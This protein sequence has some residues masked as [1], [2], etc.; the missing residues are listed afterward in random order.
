MNNCRETH[1]RLLHVSKDRIRAERKQ[2]VVK[3]STPVKTTTACNLLDSK[4]ESAHENEKAPLVLLPPRESDDQQAERSH[5]TTTI[6]GAQKSFLSLR[7][8]PVIVKNG[9]RKVKVNALPRHTLTV[10]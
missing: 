10:R 5:R 6:G 7:R 8:V 1:N 2:H 4:S 9:D 3:G